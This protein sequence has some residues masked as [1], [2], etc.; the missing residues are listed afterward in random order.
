MHEGEWAIILWEDGVMTVAPK[1]PQVV[2]DAVM[3]TTAAACKM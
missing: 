2:V 3:Q 1:G